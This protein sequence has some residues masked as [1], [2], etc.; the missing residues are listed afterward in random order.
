[1]TRL[2]ELRRAAD[3]CR[4]VVGH[5]GEGLAAQLPRLVEIVE[6]VEPRTLVADGEFGDIGLDAEAGQALPPSR[7][8]SPP[9][10]SGATSVRGVRCN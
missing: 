5:L 9:I 1:M 3:C 8:P 2:A 7:S 4:D 6:P 10:A